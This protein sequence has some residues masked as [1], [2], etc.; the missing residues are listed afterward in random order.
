MRL[1]DRVVFD[2]DRD[3]LIN[4]AYHVLRELTIE[5]SGGK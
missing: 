2:R 3:L 5:F 1:Q 4:V